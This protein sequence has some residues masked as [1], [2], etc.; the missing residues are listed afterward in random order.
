MPDTTNRITLITGANKGLGHEAA[1]RLSE[2][3]HEVYIGAR[4]EERQGDGETRGS[5]GGQ[6]PAGDPPHTGMGLSG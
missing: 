2:Q 1:R 3:G 4:D 6:V 5:H